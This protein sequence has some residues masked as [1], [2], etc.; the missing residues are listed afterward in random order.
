M[1]YTPTDEILVVI[2]CNVSLRATLK[3]YGRIRRRRG[4]LSFMVPPTEK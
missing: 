2:S 1:D 3:D 4:D